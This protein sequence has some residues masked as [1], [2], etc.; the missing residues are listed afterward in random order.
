VLLTVTD[1]L[2]ATDTRE[3]RAEPR[4]EDDDDD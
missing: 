1:D 2:G 3:H 4:E